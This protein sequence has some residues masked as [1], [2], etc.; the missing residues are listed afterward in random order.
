MHP[1]RKLARRGTITVLAAVLMAIFLAM[2]AFSVDV[3]Y[4]VHARTDLQ[5][6]T[7]AIALAAAQHLPDE[8]DAL[9]AAVRMSDDYNSANASLSCTLD[10]ADVVFGYW[11]SD[12]AMFHNPPPAKRSVNAVRITMRRTQASGNPL[13]LFFAPVLGVDSANVEANATVMSDR[14]LCGPLIGI[15]YVRVPGT[16]LTDSY[17][18]DEGPYNAA[19]AGHE[20]GLCSDG[21]ITV[22]GTALVQGSARAG[23]GYDVTITGRSVVTGPIGSRLKPLNMPPVDASEAAV[24]NDNASLPLL[25][26]G[27][28]WVSPLDANRNFHLNATKTYD[29]PPGTY[30]FNDLTL[31]GQAVLNFSGPTTVYLTGDLKRAGGTMVNNNTQLPSNLRIL[32]TGGTAD[33]TSNNDFHGLI[34]GPNTEITVSG[35]ADLFGGVVGRTL[36]MTGTG[37]VH[38]DESLDLG[39]DEFPRRI[40]LVD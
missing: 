6:T 27:N 11:D 9:A 24:M 14:G 19:T 20:A 7:D 26:Q 13:S 22:N 36:T 30:Y 32:M 25:K 21:P 17:D 31:E 16:P 2:V 4:I 39:V 28:S 38:Y 37:A 18:T 1:K 35:D 33:V 8:T 15:E 23:K 34:Y 12:D 5:R 29:M 10:P 40:A 3:G